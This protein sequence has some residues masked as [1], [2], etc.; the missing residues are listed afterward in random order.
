[1]K[2]NRF[3]MILV[4]AVLAVS[5]WT[6]TGCGGGGGSASN[7]T[8]TLRV[9]LIDAPLNASEVNVDITSVQVH[10]TGGAWKTVE[11]FTPAKHVNLLDY[12]TGGNSLMLVDS[13]LAAGHY[14]MIRLM[15]SKAEVVVNGQT[16]DVDL[17]NVAQTGVKCNGQFTVESNQLCAVTLDFN[18][19]RSFVNT[20]SGTYMLHPVM[21]MSPVNIAAK[22]TGSV[23]FQNGTGV[24]QP[25]PADVVV[26]VYP[27]G[28]AGNPDALSGGAVVQLD[29]T[30]EIP[31]IAQGT[32]DIQ[33][34]VGT[35]VVKTLSAVVITSPS[36]DLG[37]IIVVE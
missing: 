26:N 7:G 17:K 23:E 29:G 1:M 36:T 14:T 15:L 32:Y 3:L 37:K 8:G 30:F 19:Q 33:I 25:L 28:S 21:S 6:I 16:F 34:L 12:S 20:G 35:N 27:Q 22:V 10:S 4:M 2:K 24:V 9:A 31:V 18:A 5:L 11:T 13:P